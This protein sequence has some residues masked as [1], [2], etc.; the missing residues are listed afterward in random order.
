[1]ETLSA[2]CLPPGF[3]FHPTD[4]ELVSHYLRRK[5]LGLK[6]DFEVIPE[7]DI[8]K[9]EPWDL[10]ARCHVPTRDSK[11]HFFTSRDKKYPNGSRSNRATEAGYWKST[12]KDRNI[13][14]NNRV[15]GTKKTLVFHK[16][17]PPCGKRT[18]WIMHEYYINENECK[19]VPD[20]K[21]SYV[22]C[23]VTK[24]LS[25]GENF[26]PQTDDVD[27]CEK[28]PKDMTAVVAP[29][30]SSSPSENVEDIE[31]WFT[32][33]FDPNFSPISTL[34]EVKTEPKISQAGRGSLAPKQEVLDSCFP[35]EFSEDLYLLPPGENLY[36][37]LQQS[38][39][40]NFDAYGDFDIG[41]LDPL[42]ESYTLTE[43]HH[44]GFFQANNETEIASAYAANN[45]SDSEI[46][47][48]Q[49]RVKPV[50]SVSQQR[51]KLQAS[52]METRNGKS[53]SKTIEIVDRGVHLDS[54]NGN[55]L[56]VIPETLS[57]A[58]GAIRPLRNSGGMSWFR[59]VTGLPNFLG[60]RSSA[61][62][63]CCFLSACMM[64]GAG[65]LVSYFILIDARHFLG[66]FSAMELQ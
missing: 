21:G 1:M 10:P 31:K 27:H 61:T 53:L 5:I 7:V 29:K 20:G 9:H 59:R 12:G 26:Y 37:M 13:R 17:R 46:Q 55:Q 47:L 34:T 35:P 60:W 42:G 64:M 36:G 24:R 40:Q 52:K 16:G 58:S 25:E 43:N 15:I 8:Y 28:Q 23:R 48:R 50:T 41:S 38:E 4:V 2:F 54:Y 30:E 65:A 19:A 51:I 66:S 39:Y 44:D 33:L 45:N 22:L 49:R 32:E 63:N 56:N 3:G 6:I 11:W 62:T 18:E 57:D 14:S